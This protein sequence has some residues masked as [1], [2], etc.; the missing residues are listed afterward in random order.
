MERQEVE[1]RDMST[2]DIMFIAIVQSVN[3]VIQ[4]AVIITVINEIN[5]KR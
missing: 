5:K 4:I 1:V 3:L 2:G